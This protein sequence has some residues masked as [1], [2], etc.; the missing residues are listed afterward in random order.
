[1]NIYEMLQKR[2]QDKCTVSGGHIYSDATCTKR[3]HDPL[4]YHPGQ[5]GQ[6]SSRHVRNIKLKLLQLS[7]F[8]LGQY[9]TL[10]YA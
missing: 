2:N 6:N 9:R 1:M 3:S 8:N 7:D 10:T 5:T 4:D